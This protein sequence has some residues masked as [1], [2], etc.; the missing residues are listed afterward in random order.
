MNKTSCSNRFARALSLFARTALVAIALVLLPSCC[1]TGS[2]P[3]TGVIYLSHP[4]VFTRERLINRRLEER[5]WLE[6]QLKRDADFRL[7]GSIDTR[8]FVGLAVAVK[9][10]FDPLG[11]AQANAAV[12]D[13]QRNSQINQL[14]DQLQIE[15]LKKQ[16]DVVK[17]WTNG[18]VQPPTQ[19]NA[20]SAAGLTNYGSNLIAP[21]T[22]TVNLGPFTGSNLP[23]LPNPSNRVLSSSALT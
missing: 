20:S 8:E 12:Q 19:T 16:I 10:N 18:N 2:N 15:I 21:S 9:G 6:D 13:V 1:T 3:G 11:G 17:E 5:Q 23:P 22:V 4:Q 14:Q 7:Q